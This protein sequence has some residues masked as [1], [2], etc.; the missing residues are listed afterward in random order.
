MRNHV[1][2]FFTGVREIFAGIFGYFAYKIVPSVLVPC[3][4][5]LFGYDNKV[6]IRALLILVIID[7]LT[8]VAAAYMSGE[9]IRSRGILRSAVKIVVYALLVSAAHLAGQIVPGGVFIEV[10]VLTFLGLTELISIIE[11][12]G[13]MGFAVPKKMLQKLQEIRGEEEYD[14][15]KT[16][17]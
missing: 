15:A 4:G 11:N 3:I 17:L 5:V 10:S 2:D 16:T 9:L 6:T 14:N 13:K 8:G 12:S 7:F 1:Y